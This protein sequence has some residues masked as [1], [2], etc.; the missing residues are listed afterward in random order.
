MAGACPPGLAAAIANAGGAGALGAL[1]MSPDEI[2]KWAEEFRAASA[3]PYQINLWIPDDPPQ[4]D[5]VHE[6]S[7][8]E[9]L[10]R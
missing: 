5:A 10:A 8:R 4:R 3:G 6:T 2:V 9:F 1:L 7:V